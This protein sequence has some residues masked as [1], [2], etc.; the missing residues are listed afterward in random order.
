MTFVVRIIIMITSWQG[1]QYS[2]ICRTFKKF[3]R[4]HFN[5]FKCS[6]KNHI[7]EIVCFPVGALS[8]FTAHVT[9]RDVRTNEH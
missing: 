7:Q 2:V 1:F 3:A 4:Q 6:V 8:H 9:S 5:V